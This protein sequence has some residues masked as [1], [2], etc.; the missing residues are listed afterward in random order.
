MKSITIVSIEEIDERITQNKNNPVALYL[1][2]DKKMFGRTMIDSREC[3]DRI[4]VPLEKDEKEPD[5][6]LYQADEIIRFCERIFDIDELYIIHHNRYNYA[7]NIANAIAYCYDID[8]EKD[9]SVPLYTNVFQKIKAKYNVISNSLLHTLSPMDYCKK[10]L[11]I[12]Y[13]QIRQIITEKR[14]DEFNPMT[15]FDHRQCSISLKSGINLVYGIETELEQIYLH[16][17]EDV[18]YIE[19]DGVPEIADPSSVP[20]DSISDLIETYEYKNY[21]Q[22]GSILLSNNYLYLNSDIGVHRTNGGST[23][24]PEKCESYRTIQRNYKEFKSEYG[25]NE[26]YPSFDNV[27]KGIK[28]AESYLKQKNG[29]K[30]KYSTFHYKKP[31]FYYAFYEKG[32]REKIQKILKYYKDKNL[33][34]DDNLEDSCYYAAAFYAKCLSTMGHCENL[35][36]VRVLIESIYRGHECIAALEKLWNIDKYK[37]S[38]DT[39]PLNQLCLAVYALI[40]TVKPYNGKRIPEGTYR[41]CLDKIYTLTK[42]NPELNDA[43]VMTGAFAGTYCQMR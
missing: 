30:P 17:I 28:A 29:Y 9:N 21:Y 23:G 8:F 27:I 3:F 42:G 1:I 5:I 6:E 34:K 14:T 20:P 43:V 12:M 2:D 31:E 41:K 40:E 7:I 36:L 4:V 26:V 16:D 38:T 37:P 35:T 39:A 15:F 32:Y 10:M 11:S 22:K 25:G 33:L 24:I 19:F 13:D 18:E